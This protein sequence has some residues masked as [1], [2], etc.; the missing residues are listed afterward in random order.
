MSC[1]ASTFLDR[2]ELTICMTEAS[3]Q[4]AKETTDS[5]RGVLAL[6]RYSVKFEDWLD[7]DENEAMDVWQEYRV[8]V[9]ALP[10][11]K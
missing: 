2:F 4:V 7:L 8:I 3:G 10:G 6:A 1:K 11:G 9:D 5:L